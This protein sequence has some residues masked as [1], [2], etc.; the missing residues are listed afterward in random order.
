MAK[1]KTENAP[2]V[3]TVNADQALYV[4]PCGSGYS[5]LG[6]DVCLNRTRQYKAW[7]GEPVETLERGA[8]AAYEDYLATLARV[9]KRCAETGKRCDVELI[10]AL[11]G[12]EGKRVEVTT[13]SGEKSR[14]IVGKSTG[15]IPIHLEIKTRASVGGCAAYVPQGSQV[16][17][18]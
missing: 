8:L 17:V 9:R 14:F 2:R 5:C 11:K 6:F 7:L 12:L 13:P 16:R 1:A 4:I 10:P 3:V 15:F 18:I